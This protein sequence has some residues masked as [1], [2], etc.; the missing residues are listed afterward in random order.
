MPQEKGSRPQNGARPSDSH[1]PLPRSRSDFIGR[2]F[3]RTGTEPVTARSALG[4]RLLLA[5]CFT[6][7]FIAAS[8]LFAVWSTHSGRG[9]S[10]TS[11]Q[12]AVLAGVCAALAVI[13]A[14]DLVVILRRRRSERPTRRAAR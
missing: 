11:T 6:P 4:L 8:L 7:V 1:T 10:P 14:V 2:R 13:A 9:S 12:L 3:E 5:I